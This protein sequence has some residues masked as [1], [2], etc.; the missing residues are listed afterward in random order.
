VPALGAVEFSVP[1]ALAKRRGPGRDRTY[2]QG[3]MKKITTT[4]QHLPELPYLY[5]WVI[6]RVTRQM[7]EPLLGN[8]KTTQAQSITCIMFGEPSKHH[9]DPL[10]A[11]KHATATAVSFTFLGVKSTRRWQML[12][13]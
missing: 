13:R 2:D 1:R 9:A 4:A 12:E 7:P 3:I 5:F 8:E 11:V 6:C 10:R